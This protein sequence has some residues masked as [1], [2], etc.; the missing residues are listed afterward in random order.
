M[1]D[2]LA[3]NFPGERKPAGVVIPGKV[4]VSIREW[5]VPTP[6]S[7]PHDPLVTPDG[8]VWYVTYAGTVGPVRADLPATDGRQPGDPARAADAIL[9]ALDS[10]KTPLRL[11]LGNDAADRGLNIHSILEAFMQTGRSHSQ[12]LVYSGK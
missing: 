3:K 12:A 2:Y 9:Q 6:G 5:V 7:L 1:I 10:G 8:A 11:A 4:E